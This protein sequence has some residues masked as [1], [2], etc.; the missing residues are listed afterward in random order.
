MSFSD[1]ITKAVNKAVDSFIEKVSS[2]YSIDVAELRIMWNGSEVVAAKPTTRAKKSPPKKTDES[3]GELSALGKPELVAQCKARGLK[4]TGTKGDLIA[5]LSGTT[6][7]AALPKE[8]AKT[9]STKAPAKAAVVKAV[10]TKI[11]PIITVKNAFG[12]SEHKETG[13]VFSRETKSVIGKQ[14]PAG[15]I[16]PLTDAD[17]ETCNKYKI[18]YTIP[19]NL[20][21]KK[22]AIVVKDIPEDDEE[23]VG[24]ELEDEEL[25]EEEEEFGDDDVGEDFEEEELVDEE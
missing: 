25:L 23:T 6:E 1:L 11:A 19:E 5:R 8:K 17:I 20:N 13:L 3:T 2:T 9:V 22:A 7:E 10:Q 18:P 16:D 21:S 14:N 12:N 4:T 24:E 15:H